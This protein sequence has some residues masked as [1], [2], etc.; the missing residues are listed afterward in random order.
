MTTTNKKKLGRPRIRFQPDMRITVRFRAGRDDDLLAWLNELPDR[1]RATSIR[2][3]LRQRLND[4]QRG[5]DDCNPQAV[6]KHRG[7]AHE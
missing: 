1:Q 5:N 3:A 2:E 4:I 7:S 6:G